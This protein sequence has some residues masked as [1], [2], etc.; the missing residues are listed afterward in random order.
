MMQGNGAREKYSL[1][2]VVK[3][4]ANLRKAAIKPLFLPHPVRILTV[5]AV[6]KRERCIM[7]ESR[8]GNQLLN[9]SFNKMPPLEN[10]F[11]PVS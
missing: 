5:F 4:G 7:F 3:W 6:I 9:C 11:N 10:L 8:K 1:H 2:P